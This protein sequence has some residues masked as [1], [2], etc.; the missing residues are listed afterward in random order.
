MKQQKCNPFKLFLLILL[1]SAFLC[2]GCSPKERKDYNVIFINLDT[3]RYDYIDT[4]RGAKAYTPELKKFS[5]QSIVFENAFST[6][7]QTL[8]SHLSVFTSHLPHD[9]GIFSNE[10]VYD[11]RFKM[12]QQVFEE[13]GYHTAALISLGT[14]TSSTGI[15]AG[16]KE[17][18]EDLFGPDTFFVPAEKMTLEAVKMIHKLKNRCFFL[19]VHYSD[20]HTPYAPP[21]VE[22]R[23]EICIDGQ[24][25][26]HFNSYTGAIL[27]KNLP[28]SKG[29]HLIEFKVKH[30]FEDFRH[31]IIRKLSLS[32]GCSSTLENLDYSEHL[33]EGSY[34][35]NRPEGRINVSCQEDSYVEIFQIIPILKEKASVEYYRREVEYMDRFVGKFLRELEA[36]G[37]LRKTIIVIFGDHGEGHGERENFFGHTRF[38]NRQFIHV[39]LILRIPGV[40]SKRLSAP[41]SLISISPTVLEFLGIHE[42]SFISRESLLKDVQKE[43]SKERLVYSFAFRPSTRIQ[44]L[45]IIKWPHQAIFYWN[46]GQLKKKEFYNLLLSQSFSERD[47][48]E[49]EVIRKNSK[50]VHE[51][52]QKKWLKLKDIFSLT[53]PQRKT[54]DRET[55]EH[56]KTL[57]YVKD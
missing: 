42:R 21:D 16:F 39:P 12:I 36:I 40:E 26:A 11:G 44:K 37:L 23:F 17:F 4:G 43:R 24:S 1:F 2:L 51:L 48:I 31:F 20:P 28:L 55:L 22:G 25:I 13:S 38:L 18:K 41:V 10:Y 50:Q 9:L 45:S 57:G 7:A 56:L 53:Y 27:R 6:S 52:F 47:A 49:E 54:S 35:M 34:I 29:S 32:P 19:F 30:S 5:A 15:K 14:L 33:Y 46:H 8:P 3:T